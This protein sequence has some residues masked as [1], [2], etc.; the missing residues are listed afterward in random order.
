[1]LIY[2]FKYYIMKVEKGATGWLAQY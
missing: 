2:K 1:M